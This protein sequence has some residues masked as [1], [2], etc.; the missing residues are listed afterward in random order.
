MYSWLA[1]DVRY[2]LT[3]NNKHTQ[4]N[5][6]QLSIQVDPG[7]RHALHIFKPG[8]TSSLVMYIEYKCRLVAELKH[9]DFQ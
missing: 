1:T 5:W 6:F 3:T 7:T 4:S 8:V 2:V 9:A